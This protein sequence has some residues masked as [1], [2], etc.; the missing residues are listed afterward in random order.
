MQMQIRIDI[1][2]LKSVLRIDDEAAQKKINQTKIVRI[3]ETLIVPKH[4]KGGFTV[5][6][7]TNRRD[8]VLV[9]ELLD[10]HRVT[11]TRLAFDLEAEKFRQPEPDAEPAASASTYPQADPGRDLELALQ[12]GSKAALDV[13]LNY[14]PDGLYADL[15]KAKLK[16]M[17]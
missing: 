3:E 10:E 5:E 9:I 1:E 2:V 15:A 7:P 4:Q 12:I 8:G 16:E 17:P 11:I 6:E 14:H 13:F